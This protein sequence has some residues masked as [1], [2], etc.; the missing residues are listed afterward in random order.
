MTPAIPRQK[1]CTRAAGWAQFRDCF[2]ALVHL[3]F[4]GGLSGGRVTGAGRLRGTCCSRRTTSRAVAFHAF[5]GLPPKKAAGFA[6]RL[7]FSQFSNL[8]P[9]TRRA[10]CRYGG[11]HAGL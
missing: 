10:I 8:F 7:R 2:A 9:R 11:R 6:L 1:C 4:W 3:Y 5:V